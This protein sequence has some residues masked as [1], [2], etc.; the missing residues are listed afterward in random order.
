MIPFN[1]LFTQ[2]ARFCSDTTWLHIFQF[3]NEYGFHFLKIHFIHLKQWYLETKLRT[4]TLKNSKRFCGKNIYIF[5]L[6]F[7]LCT[8]AAPSFIFKLSLLA[9]I[10][11]ILRIICSFVC[12]K[13]YTFGEKVKEW[14]SYRH[15]MLLTSMVSTHSCL[16]HFFKGAYYGSG[17]RLGTDKDSELTK[18]AV[19]QW[20][21]LLD[22][23]CT[24]NYATTMTALKWPWR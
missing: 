11:S 15:I 8:T 12:L 5:A 20:T 10:S 7:P 22:S 9:Q 19:P 6:M 17:T 16:L 14:W 13:L 2:K 24:G 4:V 1:Q 21:L 3:P 18:P 23:H